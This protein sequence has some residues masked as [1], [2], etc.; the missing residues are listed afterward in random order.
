LVDRWSL[1]FEGRTFNMAGTVR[2]ARLGTRTSRARLKRGRMP[3]WSTITAG[4]SHLGYQ[5][6]PDD[7]CGRWVLRRRIG[8]GYTVTAIGLAD[9]DHAAD[10]QTILSHDEARAR[11]VEVLSMGERPAGRITVRKAIADYI[12]HLVHAGRSAR[13]TETVAVAHVLPAL[14]DV[15]VEDLTAERLRRW[16]SDLAAAPARR[17]S[18]KFGPQRYMPPP[19]DDEAVRRRRASA[20]RVLTVLKAALNFAH[21]EGRVHSADAWGK[22]VRPF[23][24]AI[25]PRTRYLTTDEATRLINA[26]QP[27]AF[28]ALVRAAL[29]SGARYSELARLQVHAFNV[30][31]GTVAIARSKSGK[32]RHVILTPEGARFFEAVTAGRRGD[33]LMFPRADGQP[34]RPANQCGPMRDAVARARIDPP[35]S[36]HGL[37]HTWASLSVM[38]GM[39][40]MVVARNMGHADTR[41]VERHYG[42][43]APSFVVDQVRAAAPRFPAGDPAPTVRPMRGRRT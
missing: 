15:V 39:P 2:E 38:A 25:A 21:I 27:P 13:A 34:W 5:R 22:R 37:R 41:M 28:R 29:E 33:E 31:S 32:A 8:N 7:R 43:L 4:K 23:A 11:A 12:D 36:F 16:L 40:L 6:W 24:G 3:H 9:D 42:H 14:G 17:R 35:I 19:A 10:G 20:N 18:S 1:F 26:C 30:D